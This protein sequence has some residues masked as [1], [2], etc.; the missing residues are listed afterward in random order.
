MLPGLEA[1]FW[2]LRGDPRL[3]AAVRGARLGRERNGQVPRQSQSEGR[4]DVRSLALIGFRD[5]IVLAH[6]G[7]LGPLFAEL[8]EEQHSRANSQR[9]AAEQGGG[10][11]TADGERAR[12][13]SGHRPVASNASNATVTPGHNNSPASFPATPS[14]SGTTTPAPPQLGTSP[15]PP[16]TGTF[17]AHAHARRRQLVATLASVLTG[18]ER[19]GMLEDLLR[20]MRTGTPA[21]LGRPA[22]DAGSSNEVGRR[23][24]FGSPLLGEPGGL[25]FDFGAAGGQGPATRTGRARAGTMDSLE[26][27][28]LPLPASLAAMRLTS[29]APPATLP[30]IASAS[31]L[32]S[33]S[34][35]PLP[36]SVPM[37]QNPSTATWT[38][39]SSAGTGPP[40]P[41]EKKRHHFLGLMRRSHSGDA[42][43]GKDKGKSKV[44]E[45]KEMRRSA[46]LNTIHG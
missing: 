1:V 30:P 39:A 33:D 16:A 4:I 23:Q 17:S 26:E 32:A 31:L 3:Q 38:S 29:I 25:E 41:K 37:A 44:E 11:A 34:F 46:T 6:L 20:T 9:S 28:E 18:D 45:T 10:F 24:S 13:S 27:E 19:Q 5:Q 21:N 35:G 43:K 15:L 36:P 42:G 22:P 12:S 8:A 40:A 14:F 7:R 2:G